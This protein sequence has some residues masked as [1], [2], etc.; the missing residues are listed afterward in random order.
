VI[1][2]PWGT[3]G[4]W[5]VKHLNWWAKW[6]GHSSQ[7]GSDQYQPSEDLF[8]IRPTGEEGKVGT[9]SPE[10]WVALCRDDATFIKSFTPHPYGTY[11]DGGCSVEVYTSEAFIEM[12]TLSPTTVIH[13]GA[14]ITQRETWT[15]TEESVDPADGAA[16]RRLLALS[17]LS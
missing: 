2:F 7:I 5:D 10:G 4:D 17:P 9:H 11:P 14:V 13:P 12:E 8:L 6:T 15:V 3:G 1:A 16:L